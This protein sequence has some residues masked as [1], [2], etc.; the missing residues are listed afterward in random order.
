MHARTTK[1]DN[2]HFVTALARGLEVLRCFDRPGLELTVSQIAKRIGFSQPTVWR[3]CQTLIECGY[4]VRSTSGAGL[5]VGAPAVTLGYAAVSGM[6][7]AELAQPYM[8]VVADELG[9][10]T[11]LSKRQ[12]LE[13]ISMAQVDGA[14]VRPDQSIGWRASLASVASGLAVLVA[15]P[16]EAR[17]RALADIPHDDASEKRR[18]R[19]VDMALREY[20][21][22]G[23]VSYRHEQRGGAFTA[24][25]IP[26]FEDG[27][28]PR[29][30]WALSCG[31]IAGLWDEASLARAGEAL[32]RARALLQPALSALEAVSLGKRAG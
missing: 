21:S 2:P 13:M 7:P 10:T 23:I 26:L 27:A 12:A 16:A 9:T 5:R 29:D 15:L 20:A 6:A 1:S 19:R 18:R 22:H 24:V 25:A 17:D 11:T 14:Y 30:Q 4:L 31:S 3:L 8:R 28:E 32:K